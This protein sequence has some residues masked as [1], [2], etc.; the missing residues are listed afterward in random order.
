MRPFIEL[1]PN[2]HP[3]AVGQRSGIPLERA[4]EILAERLH[5]EP[6]AGFAGQLE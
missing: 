4:A 5:R 3:L 2:E 6:G 1:E